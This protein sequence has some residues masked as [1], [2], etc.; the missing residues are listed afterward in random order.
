MKFFAILLFAIFLISLVNESLSNDDQ[1]VDNN[2]EEIVASLKID[3]EWQ[4]KNNI[5]LFVGWSRT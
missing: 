1:D 3:L 2:E 4:K 5:T